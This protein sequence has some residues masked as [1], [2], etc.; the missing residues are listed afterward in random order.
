[1]DIINNSPQKI[2]YDAARLAVS[3][4]TIKFHEL[5]DTL[6]TDK[7][8][9]F[10]QGALDFIIGVVVQSIEDYVSYDGHEFDGSPTSFYN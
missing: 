2:N 10:D 3:R 7:L 4:A 1:M 6:P 5:N 9:E 8:D